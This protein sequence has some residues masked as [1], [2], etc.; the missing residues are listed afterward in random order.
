MSVR[1]KFK[2]KQITHHYGT[3][4]SIKMEAE[5]DDK[6]PEDVRF[7]EATPNGHFEMSVTNPAVVEQLKLGRQFYLD[8]TPAD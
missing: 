1:A 4:Y 6:I 8:L 7:C 2:V 3:S 5:Y